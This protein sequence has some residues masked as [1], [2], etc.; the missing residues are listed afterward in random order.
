M[1]SD[2]ISSPEPLFARGRSQRLRRRRAAEDGARRLHC[3]DEVEVG[4]H[5][6]DTRQEGQA[7]SKTTNAAAESRRHPVDQPADAQRHVKMT[8]NPRRDRNM[9]QCDK[10]R[11]LPDSFT[12][13]LNFLLL[14]EMRRPDLQH[15]RSGNKTGSDIMF[16]S[17]CLQVTAEQKEP[18][19]RGRARKDVCSLDK[20]SSSVVVKSVPLQI[21]VSCHPQ[22]TN[23]STCSSTT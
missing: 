19:K 12:S 17:H 6:G 11:G 23:R 5:H 1:I 7:K 16:P 4:E 9:Q 21:S 8:Q 22:R 3:E 2:E 15:N 13:A 18:K 20:K 14:T 10:Q